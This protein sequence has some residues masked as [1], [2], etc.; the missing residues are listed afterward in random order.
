MVHVFLGSCE[1][2]V[3]D[4][5]A[6]PFVSLTTECQPEVWKCRDIVPLVGDLTFIYAGHEFERCDG[7]FTGFSIEIRKLNNLSLHCDV[8]V[9]LDLSGQIC[10][11]IVSLN[12]WWNVLNILLV[13]TWASS[14]WVAIAIVRHCVFEERVFV[15][16]LLEV[17]E[18]ER[19]KVFMVEFESLFVSL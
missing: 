5:G 3:A 19:M 7:I 15:E 8:S 13:E 1:L 2:Q 11:V 14:N 16:I 18:R 10:S 6:E 17:V 4:N 12:R 9:G